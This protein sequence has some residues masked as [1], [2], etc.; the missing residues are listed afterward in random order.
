[1]ADAPDLSLLRQR[2]N[3]IERRLGEG[4]D[5]HRRGVPAPELEGPQGQASARAA[6]DERDLAEIGAALRRIEQLLARIDATLS[7]AAT[8]LEIERMRAQLA[9]QIA[10][11]PGRGSLWLAVVTLLAGIGGLVL[12]GL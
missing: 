12:V 5:Q 3:D 11:K 2:I 6:A 7:A 8:K 10:D 4:L 1:M 9:S